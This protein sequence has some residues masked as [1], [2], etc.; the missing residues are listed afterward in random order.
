MK[1][2][3][4]ILYF[5]LY[6]I[7]EFN[8]QSSLPKNVLDS[9]WNVWTDK[10][11]SISKRFEAIQQIEVDGYLYT[12]PDSA[13][14]FNKLHY[15]LAKQLGNKKELA[16]ALNTQGSI[17][18]FK[19]EYENA[20]SLY[21]KSLN[22]RKEIGFNSGICSSLNNIA[23][24]FQDQGNSAK[25]IEY[26]T[27]SLKLS[28]KIGFDKG[29]ANALGNIGV[30]YHFQNNLE[31]ALIYHQKSLKIDQK[32]NNKNGISFT[33]NNIGT[34]YEDL[35][36]TDLAITYY[37]K[38][39]KIEKELGSQHGI[40]S[41]L[42]NIGANYNQQNKLELAKKY[43]LE[44]LVIIKKID[45][46]HVLS[47]ALNNLA[48][49]Y[50]KENKI[51]KAIETSEKSLTIAKE[52][53]ALNLVKNAANSLFEKYSKIKNFE[54]AFKM[55][56]FYIEIK[57]SI[58]NEA[59]KK[60]V[61]YQ[62][63][64]YIYEKKAATDS[65][66]NLKQKQLKDA[67]IAKQQLE[68]RNKKIQQFWFYIVLFIILF[69]TIFLYNRFKI[70]QKQ[71]SII[72]IQKSEVEKA[73]HFLAEKNK[74]ITD[75]ITY[76]KRIQSAILPSEK[77]IKSFF[78]NS[79]ILYKPKDIVAGDFYWFEVIDELI[80]LA[81]ADCTGHG[82]PGAMV[83]VVCHNALNRS[84]REFN[85][86]NPNEILDKTREIVIT[87]FEK[88]QED[89]KDGM[90]ISLCALKPKENKMFWA[91]AHNPL[92]IIRNNEIIEIKA[93]KQPIGKYANPKP[94][95]LHEFQL[96]NDD[97]IYIFTDGYQDQFGGPNEKK[98]RASQMKELFLSISEKPMEEQRNIID[99]KF[100]NWK[101]ELDQIDDVCV[102]GVRV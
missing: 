30:I 12:N 88:S 27:K 62:E 94:F 90:D 25:A 8:C 14:Y 4:F 82:V 43:L 60:Q 24:I 44:S 31:K 51:K 92:W 68:I 42:F 101:G 22:L 26:Y 50:Y 32:I 86:M 81:V 56:K 11:V 69:F 46:K 83:S 61:M 17:Y 6:F 91:G 54:K 64:Q 72:E 102:I 21:F 98:F 65:I 41:S 35:G 77:H 18:Y 73:H 76:A 1:K 84:V 15:N 58:D 40:A 87:E 53:G 3:I 97:I 57:D 34:I 67:E 93:D 5:N 28:E 48:L 19:G 95:T 55:H 9:L 96:N 59:N 78:P 7:S 63:F 36:K 45:D 79:F 23:N 33:L 38:S 37:L 99:E 16:N 66:S 80:F 49:I 75:S 70:T 89:V 47:A 85:L 71:K 20:K 29:L 100:E 10:N 74:E 13:Y 2:I 39:L 52:I